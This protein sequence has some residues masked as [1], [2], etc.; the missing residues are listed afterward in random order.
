MNHEKHHENID[1]N[2]NKK[3]IKTNASVE[4]NL[5]TMKTPALMVI[6]DDFTGALDT[7]VQF[8]KQGIPTYVACNLRNINSVCLNGYDVLVV[9]TDSRHMAPTDAVKSIMKVL[10][11]AT[12][13]GIRY[14]Y[15]KTD[16]TL[17]GNIGYELDAVMQYHGGQSIYFIP[18][19]PEMNRTTRH[20]KQ[21]IDGKILSESIFNA[22]ILNPMKTGVIRDLLAEQTNMSIVSI[23]KNQLTHDELFND[24]RTI[25]VF[26]CETTKDMEEIADKFRKTNVIPLLAGCAG[27]AKYVPALIGLKVS[28]NSQSEPL[29]QKLNIGASDE[30]SIP[31]EIQKKVTS[32]CKSSGLRKPDKKTAP[33]KFEYGKSSTEK[34]PKE[35]IPKHVKQSIEMISGIHDEFVPVKKTLI[36]CGSV[37]QMSLEQTRLA[38]ENSIPFITLLPEDILGVKIPKKVMDHAIRILN[39]EQFLLLKTVDSSEQII[40]YQNYGENKQITH[41]SLK[42]AVNMG[43][44]IRKIMTEVDIDHLI[45]FGGD[46]LH[47]VIKA[48]KIT[49]LNPQYEVSHGIPLSKF[50]INGRSVN[51]ITK[52]GG[53]GDSHTLVNIIKILY[54]KC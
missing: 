33:G 19:Y 32:T 49:G 9:D 51:L 10:R 43:R 22:D 11:M 30:D 45:V 46:T 54:Q 20:G 7:G 38:A 39:Q 5:E 6:A 25:Y 18:A 1:Q 8:S 23:I 24:M 31:S 4:R 36:V 41:V 28:K 44:I 2:H 52:A 50:V 15:K 42:I 37:N 16:S 21:Y 26:D 34:N 40:N 48:L 53:F 14:L 47:E 13:L 12:K 3:I 27:F 35:S 29:Q 17:R